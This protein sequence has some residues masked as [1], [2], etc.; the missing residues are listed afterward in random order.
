[1]L[2][3]LKFVLSDFWIFCGTVI[4]IYVTGMSV[5]MIVEAA[6]GKEVRYSLIGTGKDQGKKEGKEE[7]KNVYSKDDS[8]CQK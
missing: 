4:L 1:M 8:H 2:D 7:N 6:R 3:I 5:S